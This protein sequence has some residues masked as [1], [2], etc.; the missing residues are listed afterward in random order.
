MGSVRVVPVV[1]N[2]FSWALH[3][4]IPDDKLSVV[5]TDANLVSSLCENYE[6]MEKLLPLDGIRV[7]RS[8]QPDGSFQYEITRVGHHIFHMRNAMARLDFTK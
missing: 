6:I 7:Q 2:A 3:Q 1:N 4:A 5:L 8:I